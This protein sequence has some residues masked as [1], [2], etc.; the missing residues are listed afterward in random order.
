MVEV[1]ERRGK[2]VSP[3]SEERK[4]MVVEGEGE[5][6]GY[7]VRVSVVRSEISA[8]VQ[9]TREKQDEPRSRTQTSEKH[10]VPSLPPK[11]TALLPTKSIE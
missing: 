5:E 11:T 2:E 9:E 10:S 8:S 6:I 3:E 4:F 1:C 7:Q